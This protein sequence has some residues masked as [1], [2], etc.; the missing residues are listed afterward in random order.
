[1][2]CR[3]CLVGFLLG[4]AGCKSQTATVSNPFLTPDRVPPPQ[5]R[6]LAPGTAQPY[7]PGDPLPGA[8]TYQAP[9]PSAPPT[10][11]PGTTPPGGWGGPSPQYQQPAP[12]QGA[13]PPAGAQPYSP[14]YGVTPTGATLGPDDVG[15]RVAP[16]A[17]AVP[18]MPDLSP[19]DSLAAQPR[20]P[21]QKLLADP[22]QQPPGDVGMSSPV[23]GATLTVV[24]NA[25][26]SPWGDPG[27][28]QATY[29]ESTATLATG[30]PARFGSDG[31]QA[32]GS[33]GS[34]TAAASEG[35][36]PPAITRAGVDAAAAPAGDSRYGVGDGYQWLRGQL[37]LDGVTGMM[38]VQYMTTGADS[39][40]G[41]LPL[42]NPEV[43]ANLLPGEYVKLDGELQHAPRDD[44]TLMPVF[45][46]SGVQRQVR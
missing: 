33:S 21:I 6:V 23:G 16:L 46:V 22:R 13:P 40:G 15:G 11:A 29:A 38:F 19:A 44:D 7:Y 30:S 10:Y 1:M 4:L 17:G 8:S 43:V 3:V 9:S 28:Q 42:A 32:R 20:V 37:V 41:A 24:P 26:A 12:Y 27:L 35:F 14:N 5:T 39:Y 36:R 45:R 2:A 25:A 18:Q 34:S 31:F